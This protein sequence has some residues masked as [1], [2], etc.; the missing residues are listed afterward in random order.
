MHELALSMSFKSKPKLAR[1]H[2]LQRS[3]EPNKTL[4]LTVVITEARKGYMRRLAVQV[5]PDRVT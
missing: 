4:T 1:P 5:G 3:Y 2:T